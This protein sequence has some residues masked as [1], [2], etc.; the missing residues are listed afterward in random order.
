MLQVLQ[1]FPDPEEAPDSVR[2]GFHA[3]ACDQPPSWWE[4]LF[5]LLLA[6]ASATS[7]S[8][9]ISSATTSAGGAVDDSSAASILDMAIRK[10]LFQLQATSSGVAGTA[11]WL[12]QGGPL[13]GDVAHSQRTFLPG[14]ALTKQQPRHQQAGFLSHSTPSAA[15]ATA[16]PGEQT[17]AGPTVVLAL[18]SLPLP[19]WR[20][21][22]LAVLV[23]G[24]QPERQL[25]QGRVAVASYHRTFLLQTLLAL[26]LE[27]GDFLEVTQRQEEGAAAVSIRATAAAGASQ[28][29]HLQQQPQEVAARG[30]QEEDLLWQD[31]LFVRSLPLDL[32]LEVAA[33]LLPPGVTAEDALLVPAVTYPRHS[34]SSSG[35]VDAELATSRHTPEEQAVV[36]VP[37]SRAMLGTAL[38]IRLPWRQEYGEGGEAVPLVVV[39][40]HVLQA[41]VGPESPGRLGS[42]PME[43]PAATRPAPH[44]QAE[45][46]CWEAF[47]AGVKAACRSRPSGGTTPATSN[48]T[49]ANSSSRDGTGPEDVPAAQPTCS[50]WPSLQ[51]APEAAAS[52]QLLPSFTQLDAVQAAAAECVVELLPAAV[53]AAVVAADIPGNSNLPPTLPQGSERHAAA[54]AG[55]ASPL[56]QQQPRPPGLSR[57][58]VGSAFSQGV[59]GTEAPFTVEVPEHCRSLAKRLGVH[60][61]LDFEGCVTAL[62]HLVHCGC[63]EVDR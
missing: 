43:W 49:T 6:S 29:Q 38:S 1:C 34:S 20:H 48:S 8:G 58:P 30:Q 21:Q 26:H 13:A 46:V 7:G 55:K 19:C 22:Q 3:W 62:R 40:T 53:Y 18:D 32:L 2:W 37:L 41:V 9:A 4:K 59:F 57:A 44:L 33:D 56:G 60:T 25:L 14:G 24:S 11:A 61:E 47:F 42:T 36:A 28:Q 16:A 17:T 23:P 54:P 12:R 52:G 35:L 27:Q 31:L 15:M 45:L 63:R 51:L 10:P 50:L 39:P 5:K